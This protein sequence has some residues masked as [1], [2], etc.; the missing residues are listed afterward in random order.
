MVNYWQIIL[1]GAVQGLTEFF[2]ISSSGHLA[3]IQHFINFSTNNL[4]VDTFLHLGTV[5]SIIIVFWNDIKS[6]FTQKKWHLIWIIAIACIPTAIIG[7]CLENIINTISLQMIGIGFIITS[8]ILLISNKNIQQQQKNNKDLE[9]ITI[10]D[11]TIIGTLQGIA[12]LPGISRSG[13]TLYASLSRN[14]KP[15]TAFKFT[16]LLAI[17]VILGANILEIIKN[18]TLF[19]SLRV[20]LL[21]GLIIS[22]LF[23]IISIK[24]LKYMFKESKLWYFSIY[25][26]I[27]GIFIIMI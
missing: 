16:F 20:E 21:L 4:L 26:I 11:A 13:T 22:C 23:G 5:L 15:Q 12:V 9:D 14:L 7:F 17:P 6:I 3:I 1:L 8:I 27:L 2:P 10:R 24:M 25:L 18:F 19:K